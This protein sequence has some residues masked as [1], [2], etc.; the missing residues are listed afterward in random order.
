MVDKARQHK[1]KEVFA[2]KHFFSFWCLIVLWRSIMWLDSRDRQMIAK[3]VICKAMQYLEL[4]KDH[5]N[6]AQNSEIQ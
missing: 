2:K 4:F 5:K 3:K 6:R 1:I